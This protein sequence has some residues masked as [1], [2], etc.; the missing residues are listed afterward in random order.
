MHFERN[1][2]VKNFKPPFSKPMPPETS[3]SQI[4]LSLEPWPFWAKFLFNI[5]EG[6]LVCLCAMDFNWLPVKGFKGRKT[7]EEETAR[8]HGCSM[9]FSFQS[10]G[11]TFH[12]LKRSSVKHCPLS[13]ALS[14]PPSPTVCSLP[15]L[16]LLLLS[17]F[18]STLPVVIFSS[19][20][21]PVFYLIHFKTSHSFQ[22]E[23]RYKL[24]RSTPHRGSSKPPRFSF[25]FHQP[26]AS[27]NHN[28]VQ[29]AVSI[30]SLH[31]CICSN[32]NPQS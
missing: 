16:C 10:R 4:A 26:A 18:W 9:Q 7:T 20:T 31:V 3:C 6:T 5:Q 21:V 25:L 1:S 19:C 24:C 14:W 11:S 2:S 22:L 12:P 32:P 17:L 29:S 23:R 13:P 8:V 15:R 30:N 27:R 28:S